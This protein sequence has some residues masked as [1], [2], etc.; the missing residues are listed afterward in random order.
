MQIEEHNGNV[1]IGDRNITN[2]RFADDIPALAREEH[3]LETLVESLDKNLHT[4]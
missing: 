1:S 2:L 4:V 3:E